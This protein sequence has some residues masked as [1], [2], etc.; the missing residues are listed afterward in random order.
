MKT[1]MIIVVLTLLVGCAVVPIAPYS[2]Y[3]PA[4]PSPYYASPGYG[5]GSGYYRPSYYGYYGPRSGGYYGRG[6]YGYYGGYGHYR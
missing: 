1:A 6:G 5:Y 2:A 3:V 4:Y